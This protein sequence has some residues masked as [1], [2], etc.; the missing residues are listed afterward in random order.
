MREARTYPHGAVAS[1]HYLA[2][3]AGLAMLAVGRQRDR[4]RAR[5]Q[6]RARR[7]HAVH[8]RLRRRPARDRVGRR[9]ARLRGCRA[10]AAGRDGRGSARA[11][12]RTPEPD[13]RH[14]DVRA[15]PGD[16]ARRT[17][18]GWFNL[19]EKWGT[20]SFGELATTA[21]RYAEDGFPLTR[22]GAQFFTGC[23]LTYD[24][25][26]LHDFGRAIRRPSPATGSASPHSRARS[27]PSPTTAPTATTRAR[28]A[29]R[30]RR[31]CT[32]RVRS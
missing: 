5:R 6:P 16:R 9:R 32:T 7:R 17:V 18:D 4:R 14:A 22:R 28:S 30:S 25:F 15:A 27:A 31:G 8:V 1:P 13:G 2:T 19:L 20:R 26:G 21:L 24:H 12:R 29:T 3:A 10:C 23:R 11:Q